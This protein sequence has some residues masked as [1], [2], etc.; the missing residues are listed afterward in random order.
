MNCL[1][2][3]NVKYWDDNMIQ[4][5]LDFIVLDAI[6]YTLNN[7]DKKGLIVCPKGIQQVIFGSITQAL[8]LLDYGK[9]IEHIFNSDRNIKFKN[10]CCIH[11]VSDE[12]GLRGISVNKVWLVD[13]E[14]L[15]EEVWTCLYPVASTTGAEIVKL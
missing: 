6:H 1:V 5:T 15:F 2:H 9:Y 14:Q 10:G 3:F 13:H 11:L 8:D 4:E 12:M 7:H